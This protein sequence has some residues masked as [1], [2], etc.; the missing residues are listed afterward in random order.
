[1]SKPSLA[2]IGGSGLY[3]MRGLQNIEQRAI[4]TPFGEPSSPILV[5]DF[6]G[7]QVAFLARHGPDHTFS[8]SQV[9]YRAN[10]YA[11][12]LLGVERIIA[13][14]AAGSLREDFAPG[15]VVIPDQLYDNTKARE[16]TFFDEGIVAH[17]GVAGP[18]CP[19]LS[20]QLGQS[21]GEAGGTV[22]K[23]GGYITV[24]GPRF[25]TKA[26]SNTYR[27]WGMS[28]IGMTTAPEVFLAREAEICYAVMAHVTDY[29]VWHAS[30]DPV[31][32]EMVIRTLAENTQLAQGSIKN[33]IATIADT[34]DCDCGDALADALIT[35]RS[36]M[37]ESM[38]SK[39]G[40]IVSRYLS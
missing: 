34:R 37:S 28:I 6:K 30:E 8:P 18:F 3:S 38:I 1:M 35:K 24:E 2:I 16:S 10:I 14:S 22:H 39:L 11:L 36:A 9:N 31:S 40:P 29:D 19:D 25:S 33:L 32:V 4:E 5:G 21:V 23:G 7:K 27:A 12:K 17:I 20:A 15:E 13:V 26:E